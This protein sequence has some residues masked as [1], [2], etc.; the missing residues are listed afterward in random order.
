M[1]WVGTWTTS[2]VPTEG[3]SLANQT[4]RMIGRVSLGGRRVRVRGTTR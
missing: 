1:G 3:L 4:L 2:P